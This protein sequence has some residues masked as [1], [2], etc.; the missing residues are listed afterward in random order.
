M[1]HH[2]DEQQKHPERAR[3][4]DAKESTWIE[5]FFEG[6][7][8]R[9]RYLVIM[10][11]VSSLLGSMVLFII[12]SLDMVDVLKKTWGYYILGDHSYDL[13]AKVVG[14]LIG[15]IDLYLIAVVLL[16]FSFGIY[17]LFVS[18]IDEAQESESSQILEIRSL[19]ELKDKIAKVIIMVLIVRY[20]QMVLDMSFNGALEMLYLAISILGLSLA[21]FFLHKAGGH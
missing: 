15:A 5:N 21:L 1:A 12:G 13:H 4:E 19:D 17:E 2:E 16:I 9:S 10:A 18:Q 11:V 6:T 3:A 8:W 20:F 14:E 7:L